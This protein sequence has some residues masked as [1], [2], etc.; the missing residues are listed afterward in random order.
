[1]AGVVLFSTSVSAGLSSFGWAVSLFLW[2]VFDTTGVAILFYWFFLYLR[3]QSD[4]TIRAINTTT[5]TKI[6][7]KV[8]VSRPAILEPSFS[9]LV[10]S[11]LLLGVSGTRVGSVGSVGFVGSTGSTASSWAS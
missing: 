9:G 11:R 5:P 8:I 10:V 4:T 6:R 7:V 1:M 2:T 3:V